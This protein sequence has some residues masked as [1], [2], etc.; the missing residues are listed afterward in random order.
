MSN[1]E[2]PQDVP[3]AGLV[4]VSQEQT[5][6]FDLTPKHKETLEQMTVSYMQRSKIP[7]DT[8]GLA[9]GKEIVADALSRGMEANGVTGVAA[10]TNLRSL[11]KEGMEQRAQV[12]SH[13]TRVYRENQNE[14]RSGDDRC[15]GPYALP[16]RQLSRV[17]R[18]VARPATSKLVESKKLSE[19][20]EKRRE[21]LPHLAHAIVSG[22]PKDQ[23][24]D[25]SL[26]MF[27]DPS[28]QAKLVRN[29]IVSMWFR[30]NP[31]PL[32]QIQ[33]LQQF[34]NLAQEALDMRILAPLVEVVAASK[35]E[36]PL[37]IAEY[38]RDLGV[39]VSDLFQKARDRFSPN[40]L[41]D[42]NSPNFRDIV[43]NF[44]DRKLLLLHP[45]LEEQELV[46]DGKRYGESDYSLWGPQ[47]S[48]DMGGVRVP[49]EEILERAR[50]IAIA[51][52]RNG[53]RFQEGINIWTTLKRGEERTEKRKEALSHLLQGTEETLAAAGIET[54]P[55]SEFDNTLA[56]NVRKAEDYK[57]KRGVYREDRRILRRG[58]ENLQ[59]I[60][61]LDEELRRENGGKLPDEMVLPWS[62]SAEDSKKRIH[63][64]LLAAQRRAEFEAQE[65]FMRDF[66][67]REIPVLD[68]EEVYDFPVMDTPT[69]ERMLDKL[70][71]DQ[72]LIESHRGG[73]IPADIEIGEVGRYID[74]TVRNLRSEVEYM[75]RHTTHKE[76]H[77]TSKEKRRLDDFVGLQQSLAGVMKVASG[78]TGIPKLFYAYSLASRISSLEKIIAAR[79]KREDMEGKDISQKK[80]GKAEF[81]MNVKVAHIEAPKIETP[82]EETVLLHH[83]HEWKDV[84]AISHRLRRFPFPTSINSKEELI[85]WAGKMLHEL[86]GLPLSFPRVSRDYAPSEFQEMNRKNQKDALTS[87]ITIA[88]SP[89]FPSDELLKGLKPRVLLSALSNRYAYMKAR[90]ELEVDEKN[91][92]ELHEELQS[93][94]LERYRL[95]LGQQRDN[96]ARQRK[97]I[98]DRDLKKEFISSM[99]TLDLAIDIP[100]QEQ[101]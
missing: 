101:S 17:G 71:Q 80:M 47:W 19:L 44:F 35:G 16:A 26:D 41:T 10:N 32:L 2:I 20:E 46:V 42:R 63:T 76:R 91:Y 39:Q 57:W 3:G 67:S 29:S 73:I 86:P 6:L 49:N 37:P 78:M 54:M 72:G 75:S 4:P 36:D 69:V 43:Y 13:A 21:L 66:F 68:R 60:R 9:L 70:K 94:A 89:L 38:I 1:P 84:R 5:P 12:A 45:A 33:D 52:G 83:L 82:E 93:I 15:I 85:Q 59:K 99:R 55:V 96:Y 92:K 100:Q 11:V 95:H 79:T 8:D 28:S 98:E 97:E 53:T 64:V 48:V 27:P 58:D 7:F 90:A 56:T 61:E 23:F 30:G 51:Q 40:E 77:G 24:P 50:R 88:N 74:I 31:L 65:T 81:E 62:L 25:V 14:V 87:L 18:E 34:T 22:L